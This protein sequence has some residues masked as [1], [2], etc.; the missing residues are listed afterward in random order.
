LHLDPTLPPPLPNRLGKDH[1][2]IHVEAEQITRGWI[3]K[4]YDEPDEQQVTI[5]RRPPTSYSPESSHI[6]TTD[7]RR[8][9]VQRLSSAATFLRDKTTLRDSLYSLYQEIIKLCDTGNQESSDDDTLCNVLVHTRDIILRRNEC[10]N[11]WNML[12]STRL[13]LGDS[14]DTEN[15]KL[16]RNAQRYNI[17]LLELYGM[18]LFL[19]VLSVADRVLRDYESI[20][21]LDLWST[22]ARWELYQIGFRQQ[23]AE[24]FEHRYD[25]Q[26][27]HSNL[28][29]RAK[30]MKKTTSQ[31]TTRFP[32]QHGLLLY[33]EKSD[34]G[35]IWLLFPSMKK[36]MYG[37]M[38]ENQMSAM[39]R[40]G[41]H[42]GEIDPQSLKDG[43]KDALSR[44]G[45]IEYP[46]VLVKVNGQH[47]LYTKDE[48]VW[49]QSGLLEYGNPPKGQSQPVRWV[50][51]SQPSPETLVALHGYRPSEYL[52]DAR[53]ECDRVL[54]EAAE[55]RGVVRDVSCSLTINLEK[56][57]YRIDLNEGL[58]TIARKETP[59][60]DEI[61]R[62][63]RYPQRIG[64]YFSTSDGTYL[65]W[66]PQQDVKY[67]EVRIKNKDG[68]YE[69][70]HLSVF[71]PLIHRYS[72]YSDSYKLPKACEDFLMTKAGEDITLR[73]MVD[74]QRKDRGF[75]KY[76]KVQLDGLQ[77]R[78]HPIG[79]EMEDMG[80][81]D[82]ALLSECGQIVDVD[83]GTRYDFEIDSEALVRLRLTHILSDYPRL[84]NSIIGHIEELEAAELEDHKQSEEETYV[85]ERTGL[86]F[87]SVEIQESSRRR[88]L[89]VIVYLCNVNDETDI[90]EVTVISLS[91]EM[92]K[93]QSIA[94][95]LIEKEVRHNLQVQGIVADMYEDILGEVE[96]KLE[97]H[98]VK[99][100][101]F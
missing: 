22:V 19:A 101:Y 60:T 23:D 33:Q 1:E 47:V 4:E 15:R 84:Q 99:I 78:G 75:K 71:K 85:K 94:Y 97:H 31:K 91:S 13:S 36:T 48:G 11:L 59:Y 58:K 24:E 45:W 3:H 30:Q 64:E 9:E 18:N 82:V 7:S 6:D 88:S 14:L 61:I 40:Y 49:I 83:T 21:C 79:L 44:E 81:F 25:F 52:V 8:R 26:A 51:L 50:R 46:I 87:V 56:K 72:F 92:V 73:I 74:E 38:L 76:L 29:W 28:T 90:E 62:F 67:D 34:G 10:Q 80:I 63:L 43:A 98:G 89:D 55:W 100:D 17:E 2:G 68:K 57:E 5:I 39:L 53:I 41:W 70:Y 77:G 32:E 42:Q 54:Q 37:T 69:F 20:H 66:N 93:I 86:R 35:S 96:N 27:I 16:L 95:D 65:K 12:R